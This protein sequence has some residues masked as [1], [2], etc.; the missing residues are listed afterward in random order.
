MACP[1]DN[2]ATIYYNGNSQSATACIDVACPNPPSPFYHVTSS[3]FNASSVIGNNPPFLNLIMVDDYV[4]FVID[5]PFQFNQCTFIMGSGSRMEVNQNISVDLTNSLIYSC[6][7]MWQG[8]T[9]KQGASVTVRNSTIRDADEGIFAHA[10][11]SF[12]IIDSKIHDCIKG[13]VTEAPGVLTNT[14][15]YVVGSSFGLT[16]FMLKGPY[17]GQTG[18]GTVGRAGMLLNDVVMSIGDNTADANEFFNINYGIEIHNSHINVINC[19]FDK[20]VPDNFYTNVG[21]LKPMGCAINARA[22]RDNMQLNVFPLANA[23]IKTITDATIGVYTNL[24]NARITNVSMVN[25]YK[26]VQ[27]E[28]SR[29]CTVNINSCEIN[30]IYRGIDWSNND[31]ANL[32]V[33]QGNTITVEPSGSGNFKGAACIS[34]AELNAA[35]NGRYIVSDN[36]N[37]TTISAGAGILTNTVSNARIEANQIFTTEGI[38]PAPGSAGIAITAG[39]RNTILCNTVTNTISSNLTTK[40]IYNSQSSNNRYDCNNLFS[41][42]NGMFFSGTLS[43]NTSMKGNKMDNNYIGLYLDNTAVIGQ[44][45]IVPSPGNPYPAYHGNKWTGTF[46]STYGAVNM[47]AN[48]FNDLL[49]NRF[50]IRDPASGGQAVH[51]PVVPNGIVTW[52]NNNGWFDLQSTGSTFECHPSPGIPVCGGALAGGGDEK[53][54]EGLR[55]SIIQDS[56]VTVEYIPESKSMAKLYV[57]EELS[58]DSVLLASDPAY[59]NFKNVNAGLDIGKLFEVKEILKQKGFLSEQNMLT[60]NESDS[61]IQLY[62]SQIKSLDSLDAIDSVLN[63]SLQRENLISSIHLQQQIIASIIGQITN[64]DNTIIQ[65]ANALNN[66]VSGNEVPYDNEK[67]VNGKAIQYSSSGSSAL[68]NDITQLLQIA[69]Q[70]PAAG[71]PAVYT[72]RALLETFTDSIVYDDENFCLQSGYFRVIN[73]TKPVQIQELIVVP[74]PASESIEISLR[75]VTEGICRIRLINSHGKPLL[76]HEFNCADNVLQIDVSNIPPGMYFVEALLPESL[77]KNTKL[78]IVR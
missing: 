21:V 38:L 73:E 4:S 48:T 39:N 25:V 33:A 52:P 70:C 45:P 22:T 63:F 20:I 24:Y 69:H 72:A 76:Q 1:N 2:T 49:Q 9:L 16:A 43:M 5:V 60:L 12:R 51:L 34:M 37:L 29:K 78:V 15:G 44:Q 6:P 31:G 57:Y 46:G 74:N 17:S 61:L 53:M 27:S 50:T 55:M 58:T 32:M 28:Q 54:E 10:G 23:G 14:T 8:I 26:G 62:L 35:A 3:D 11:S 40:G 30:A 42:A 66:Q 18:F 56:S 47:N 71:G 68:T 77:Y 65:N 41:S 64:V 7:Q 13:V 59:G 19:Q 36:P 67:F 75:N